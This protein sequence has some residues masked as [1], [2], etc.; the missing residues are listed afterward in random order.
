MLDVF[1][2]LLKTNVLKTVIFNFKVFPI[3][4]AIH[5]PILYF[6]HCQ[7]F[8]R[9]KVEL[10]VK[11]RFGLLMIGKNRSLSYGPKG[12]HTD[13]T[14]FKLNGVLE[15]RGY[16]NEFA[17]GCKIYI[18][19]G[20]RLVLNN[21]LLLQNR[22][23]IH[24]ANSITIGSNIQVSWES[25]LFDTNMH[26]LVDTNGNVRNNKGTIIIED[27][28]WIGNRCTIQ[29]GTHLPDNTVVASNS[30]VNKDFSALP[31]G[32]IAGS[33]AKHVKAGVKRIFDYNTE[34]KLDSFFEQNPDIESINISKL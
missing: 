1:K 8:M 24:C 21:D 9:G 29:K 22:C 4:T 33:P 2:T 7:V 15:L 19:K 26:Y 18:K 13:V 14:Y 16:N 11:P 27:N 20:G 30:M 23:K 6:G 12:Y 31:A 32:V 25:Q 5:L 17:N 34:R 3:K 28:C 10:K